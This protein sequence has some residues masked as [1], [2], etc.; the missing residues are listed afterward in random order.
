MRSSQCSG[1]QQ[2]TDSSE[3]AQSARFA[4][5]S[6]SL[7]ET[8]SGLNSRMSRSTWVGY[9]YGD[10]SVRQSDRFVEVAS[11]VRL[12]VL[13][14]SCRPVLSSSLLPSRP[15]VSAAASP[16]M[17]TGLTANKLARTPSPEAMA[18]QNLQSDAALHQVA[19]ATSV[20]PA[21]SASLR[22]WQ[23][24]LSCVQNHT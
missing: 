1:K 7:L 8:A 17:Q 15:W 14:R 21:G 22:N 16:L 6:R 12:E 24:V 3:S 13:D 5:V 4:W 9:V 18:A 10:L 20:L 19:A 2:T 11:L 23:V